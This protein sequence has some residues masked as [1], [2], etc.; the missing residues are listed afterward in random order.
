[1]KSLLKRY[2]AFFVAVALV[3]TV[4]WA[5][6]FGLMD[7]PSDREKLALFVV[8]NGCDEDFFNDKLASASDEVVQT[9]I[10]CHSEKESMF[11]DYLQTQGF[12]TADL[13]IFPT[14][15]FDDE[16]FATALLPLTDAI[17]SFLPSQS[18]TVQ[19]GG[20]TYAVIVKDDTTDIFGDKIDFDQGVSYCIAVNLTSKNAVLGQND[21]ALVALKNLLTK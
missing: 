3:A 6:A 5:V 18:K 20:T 1:M 4:F 10:F 11:A 16:V 14:S 19:S 21:N 8:A 2:A 13:L 17:V 7:K 12:L 15:F 9:H